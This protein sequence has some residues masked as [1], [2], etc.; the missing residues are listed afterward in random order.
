MDNTRFS[1]QVLRSYNASPNI[2][3][4]VRGIKA[5]VAVQTSDSLTFTSY[6]RVSVEDRGITETDR[7][8]QREP[9][10]PSKTLNSTSFPVPRALSPATHTLPAP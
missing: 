3:R 4:A 1:S 5:V 7:S 6:T 10:H 9:G 8:A 2:L